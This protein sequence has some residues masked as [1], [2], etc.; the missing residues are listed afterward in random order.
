MNEFHL[1]KLTTSKRQPFIQKI[2]ATNSSYVCYEAKSIIVSIFGLPLN[3]FSIKI[4][5]AYVK[6]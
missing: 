2:D 4:R 5:G 1:C 3:K 6:T